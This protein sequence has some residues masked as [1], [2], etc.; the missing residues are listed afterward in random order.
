RRVTPP[1]DLPQ[2]GRIDVRGEA[3][4]E[5]ETELGV[6][7]RLE[8]GQLR[9]GEL[10]EFRGKIETAVG[11]QAGG[12]RIGESERFGLAASGD[13]LHEKGGTG[14]RPGRAE[15]ER[16]EMEDGVGDAGGL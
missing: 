4:E 13:E 3:A 14:A 16:A 8:P 9:G 1:D 6:A 10:R 5:F 2:R 11:S 7:Q 12:D 15:S